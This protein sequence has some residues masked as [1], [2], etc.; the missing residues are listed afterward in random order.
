MTDKNTFCHLP[1][2]SLFIGA[3]G[4]V[5]NCCPSRNILGNLNDTPIERIIN[6]QTHKEIQNNIT[7]D[8]WHDNCGLCKEIEDIGQI[9]YRNIA[10]PV[11]NFFDI[12]DITESNKN[13]HKFKILDIRWSNTCNLAC[14]YCSEKFSSTWAAIKKIDIGASKNYYPN[15]INYIE[16]HRAEIER[17]D[18]LGGEP[19]ILK[20]NAELLSKF[21]NK[22]I[23]IQVVTSGSI[24]LSK[25]S[26][27]KELIKFSNVNF[28][29]SFENTKDRYEY[30]RHNASWELLTNNIKYIKEN[31]NFRLTAL[32]IY[33]IYSA[34]DIDNFYEVLPLFNSVAWNML[35]YPTE[36]NLFNFPKQ[37][38]NI[39]LEKLN[40]VI[41]KYGDQQSLGIDFLH[42]TKN[43]IET[44]TSD[45]PYPNFLSFTDNLETN[46]LTNKKYSFFELW[47]ELNFLKDDK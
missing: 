1:W 12:N 36:L 22:D 21:T 16:N 3:Q 6:N 17:I 35:V 39:A 5:R 19:L 42:N 9:S 45:T 33:N 7:E 37:V 28:G 11:E 40:S 20:E 38:R 23:E 32:P 30:V 4:D 18:L 27:F 15:V 13:F 46:L 41:K 29:I 47:P 43:L 10:Q 2:T 8:T 34:L 14:N 44:N 24:D 26:V 31:T 25:S